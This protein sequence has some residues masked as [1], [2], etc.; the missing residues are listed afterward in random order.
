ML[1]ETPLPY[2][3]YFIYLLTYILISSLNIS[4]FYLRP[5]NIVHLLDK[6]V[7]SMRM[8]ILFGLQLYL[9]TLES[10]LIQSKCSINMCSTEE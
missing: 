3:V 1:M 7:S 5:L 9:G 4:V 2:F 6:N 10:Y 8:G